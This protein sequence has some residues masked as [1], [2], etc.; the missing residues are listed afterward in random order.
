[1]F[2]F[3]FSCLKMF[4]LIIIV[5]RACT[6]R[7]ISR[8]ITLKNTIFWK[9]LSRCF[10]DTIYIYIRK[11]LSE[12]SFKSLAVVFILVSYIW[13]SDHT[14]RINTLLLISWTLI[15]TRCCMFC[16]HVTKQETVIMNWSFAHIINNS[17]LL[18]CWFKWFFISTQ[19]QRDF[20]MLS[21]NLYKDSRCWH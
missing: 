13:R 10:A 4:F 15:P 16:V 5:W 8:S 7:K 2:Q 6:I 17:V 12:I 11:M 14:Q 3:G 19:L 21:C 9:Q 20:T 1:M 18:Y